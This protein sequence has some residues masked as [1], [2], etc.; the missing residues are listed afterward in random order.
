[1]NDIIKEVDAGWEPLNEIWKNTIYL[2]LDYLIY[3][4]HI[5]LIKKYLLCIQLF[6][7]SVCKF[8]QLITYYVYNITCFL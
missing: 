6:N 3:M 1:M 8:D 4:Y 7:K 5:I 2:D